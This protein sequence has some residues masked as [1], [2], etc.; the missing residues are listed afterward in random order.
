MKFL[1]VLILTLGGGVCSA[2]EN[3]DCD[4]LVGWWQ[5]ERFE[6]EVGEN[7]AETSVFL[8]NGMFYVQFDMDNGLN[9]RT[10][11]ESG[12][13]ECDGDK[14]ILATTALKGQSFLNI[15]IYDILE[16]NT[17]YIKVA[18]E[19]T[20]CSLVYGQCEEAVHEAIKIPDPQPEDIC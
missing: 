11:Y 20:D 8:P 5:G 7:I 19:S 9:Q 6:Y 12:R 15:A 10:Q 18:L 3:Y 14:L 13:W 2:A 1:T 4:D 17:T 16:L